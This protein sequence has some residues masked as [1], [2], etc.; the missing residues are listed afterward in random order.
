[1]SWLQFTILILY[2]G[3]FLALIG[4]EL[5]HIKRLLTE[6]RDNLK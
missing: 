6:I 1:M 2:F 4:N 5:S 3:G